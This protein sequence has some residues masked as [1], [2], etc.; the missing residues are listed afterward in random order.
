[1]E[2]GAVAVNPRPQQAFR[3]A[4]IRQKYHFLN[5]AG[6]L[7]GSHPPSF[8]QL[9]QSLVAGDFLEKR[10]SRLQIEIV[11]EAL[12]CRD[13]FSN[14]GGSSREHATDR[15]NPSAPIRVGDAKKRKPRVNAWI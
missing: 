1:M 8:F 6:R 12:R 5:P 15:K 7:Q 10:N 13:P 11:H 9:I 14:I 2:R 3:A 4:S